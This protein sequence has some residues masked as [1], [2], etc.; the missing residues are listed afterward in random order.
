M[1]QPVCALSERI[2]HNVPLSPFT[3]FKIGGPAEHFLQVETEE[4][5]IAAVEMAHLGKMPFF[6]LG[7]GSNLVIADDGL[8]GLVIRNNSSNRLQVCRDKSRLTISSGIPLWDVVTLARDN[9]LAGM[10]SFAGIPGS[11]GGA[12]YGNAGAYGV[13]IGDMLIDAE[14]LTADGKVC[15]VGNAFFEFAYRT[16]ALKGLP[17][18]LLNVT[19]QLRPGKA[20]EVGEKVKEILQT[21]HS[22]HPP[23]SVGSAGSFFKNLPPNP[24]ESRRRPAGEVLEKAGAKDMSCGGA[25]VYAKHANFIV[26]YGKA[27]AADVRHLAHML[28]ERVLATFGIELSEEVSYV[29]G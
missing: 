15:R 17:V 7:G 28:K 13:S 6:L 29:G 22:K 1:V 5:L 14:I 4:E 2:Q 16:S 25:S 27:T 3:T 18:Y 12:V 8:R 11:L 9:D 21:R 20:E 26:N 24:G 19:L 10:E 23:Q